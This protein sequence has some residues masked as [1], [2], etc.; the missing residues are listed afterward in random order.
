MTTINLETIEEKADDFAYITFKM[1][2]L[3][4]EDDN[5]F[6]SIENTSKRINSCIYACVNNDDK[7]LKNAK[8]GV[9]KA[10]NRLKNEEDL[11]ILSYTT[12]ETIVNIINNKL[13]KR[14]A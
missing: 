9:L 2:A 11:P 3:M 6:Y 4:H 5:S 10:F 12:I 7:L 8:I 1:Q 14:S 13:E